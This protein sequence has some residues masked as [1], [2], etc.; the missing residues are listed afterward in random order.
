MNRHDHHPDHPPRA[1]AR[2]AWET[3][4]PLAIAGFAMF[5]VLAAALIGLIVDPRVI[6]GAPAWLKPAKFAISIAHL[7]VHVD[8]AADLR[9]RLARARSGLVSWVTA[10][11]LVLEMVLIAG[12]AALGTTSHFNVSTPAPRARLV[13]HGQ[14]DRGRPGWPTLVVGVLLLRQRMVDAAF[15]W[16]LRLGVLISVGR[17]G[18]GV[19][20]DHTDRGA[21]AGGGRGDRDLPV[22]GA[23]SVGVP[24]GGPGCRSW[25]GAPRVETCGRPTSSA[26]TACRCCR[27]SACCSPGARRPGC[28]RGTGSPWCGRPAWPTSASSLLTTWQ[29]LRAQPLWRPTR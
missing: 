2:R 6:T 12:A 13:G 9:H 26:C 3:N 22:A 4:R 29:A 21:T 16:S 18:R 1:T 11:A 25:A 14:H 17:H 8:L 7:L 15:A 28:G 27:S 5:A 23:H 19:L 20:H 24:D 10:V